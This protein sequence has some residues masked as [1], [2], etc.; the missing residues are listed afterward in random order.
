MNKELLETVIKNH[1][2]VIINFRTDE[3]LRDR[4]YDMICKECLVRAKCLKKLNRKF[5]HKEKKVKPYKT[6]RSESLKFLFV[7][8]KPCS[9][10]IKEIMRFL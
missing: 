3:E 2:N 4:A 6:V 10:G 7:I 9:Q 1:R 5:V 8:Q